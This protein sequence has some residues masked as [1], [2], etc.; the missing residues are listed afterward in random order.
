MTDFETKYLFTQYSLLI[1]QVVLVG[2]TV[3]FYRKLVLNDNQRERRAIE[4][5]IKHWCKCVFR[6]VDSPGALQRAGETT[7]KRFPQNVNLILRAYEEFSVEEPSPDRPVL[8][9]FLEAMEGV[10][11]GKW[12]LW[13][14]AMRGKLDIYN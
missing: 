3:F 7:R 5:E 6:G 4:A 2:V 14:D 12:P 9:K 11:S 1:V 10:E 8:Y 13:G